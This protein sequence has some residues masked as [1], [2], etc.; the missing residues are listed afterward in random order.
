MDTTEELENFFDDLEEFNNR[1]NL[2]L[3]IDD[4]GNSFYD[5]VGSETIDI[6]PVYSTNNSTTTNIKKYIKKSNN[7]LF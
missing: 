7:N 6:I 4:F 1:K 5:Y 3:M 2:R